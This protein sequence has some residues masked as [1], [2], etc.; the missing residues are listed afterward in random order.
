MR[1]AFSNTAL[2]ANFATDKP[3]GKSRQR[4]RSISSAMH[5]ARSL[6]PHKTAVELARI[7][8]TSVRTA[9]RWLAGST[10]STDALTALLRSEHGLDF[11]AAIMT[12]AEPMWWHRA[13]AYFAAIDAQ[14]LQRATRRKLKE[15]IDADTAISADIERADALLVQDEDFYGR[16]V[17]ALRAASRA[18]HRPLARKHR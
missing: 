10:L 15:V 16:H 1:R 12:G 4:R 18:P 13:K 17:D 2:S 14:R 9:E 6:W 11:L 5:A 8:N 3:V 7:T